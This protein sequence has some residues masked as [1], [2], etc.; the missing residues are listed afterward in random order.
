MRLSTHFS[1]FEKL[2]EH[3][4]PDD[5]IIQFYQTTAKGIVMIMSPRYSF[6]VRFL[7]KVGNGHYL[8]L[9]K[10]IET[11]ESVQPENQKNNVVTANIHLSAYRY[12]EG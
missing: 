10:S 5:L 7:K 3:Q 2:S 11:K 4:F 1:A 12:T 8:S 9:I 6:Y